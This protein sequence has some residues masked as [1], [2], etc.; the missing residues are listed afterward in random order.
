M[1]IILILPIHDGIIFGGVFAESML[2]EDPANLFQGL[3]IFSTTSLKDG[4]GEHVRITDILGFLTKTQYCSCLSFFPSILIFP[5][6]AVQMFFFSCFSSVSM[7]R[8]GQVQMRRGRTLRPMMRPL[9]R[10][11]LSL[12]ASAK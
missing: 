2:I 5:G 11:K 9:Q 10:N 6:W 8:F 12:T 7:S 4:R 3:I 1:K